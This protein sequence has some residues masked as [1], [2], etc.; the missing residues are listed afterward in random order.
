MGQ[1][2][3]VP[4]QIPTQV[5]TQV[6]TQTSTQ[7][8]TEFPSQ[9]LVPADNSEAL[10]ALDDLQLQESFVAQVL[11]VIDEAARA[12]AEGAPRWIDPDVFGNEREGERMARHTLRAQARVYE[13]LDLATTALAQH[14][15]SL[16]EFRDGVRQVEAAT[17]EQLATVQARL[18][19]VAP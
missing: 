11:E 16:S 8:P 3:A 15:S 13:A 10:A 5:P 9:L 14:H 4:P 17:V 2:D 18:G 19:D 6:P 7:V 12:V 1:P